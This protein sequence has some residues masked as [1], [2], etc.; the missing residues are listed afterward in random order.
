MKKLFSLLPLLFTF[1]IL[2]AQN[3]EREADAY[4]DEGNFTA[5]Q[6]LYLKTLKTDSTNVDAKHRLGICYLG[7]NIERSV[8]IPLLEFVVKQDKFD[9]YAWYDLARAY[10]YNHQFD[11]AIANYKKYIAEGRDDLFIKLAKLGKEQCENAK[12][13][14]AK[15]IDVAFYN[16]GSDVNT[17][18]NEFQP[19]I[20]AD[21][22]TLVYT[23]DQ[24]FDSRYNVHINNVYIAEN[25]EGEWHRPLTVG[26]VNSGEDEFVSGL[27]ANDEFVFI[28]YQRY[29]A[30]DDIF[31]AEKKEKRISRPESIGEFINTSAVESGATLSYSGDTL[32]FASDRDG[33]L[34]GLDLWMSLK[35]PNGNWATPI[36][37]GEPI[38]TPYD[39]DFP[40]IMPDGKNMF[41]SSTGHTSMGGYDVF[42]TKLNGTTGKWSKPQNFG[43]PVN[44]TYD[45]FT[46]AMSSNHRYAYVS[47][48]R[49]EGKGGMDI[50][51]IVF[52]NVNAN[53]FLHKGEIV[54]GE[55]DNQ[56][57][58]SGD[59]DVEIKVHDVENNKLFGKYQ[60]NSDKNQ[61]L[62]AL[63]PG[64]FTLFVNAEGFKPYKEDVFVPDLLKNQ[65][66][67][68]KVTLQSL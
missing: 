67:N 45:N 18:F 6:E 55:G 19:Y 33:G 8:A 22:S 41:F 32:I 34:G 65:T 57:A 27:A 49:P 58:L 63:P 47:D 66:Y 20:P 16:V 14:I 62:L 56:T 38:N 40:H 37:M 50:Y 17:E 53:I 51:R 52:H 43:Y 28:K 31:I 48:V 60:Y 13:L 26:V 44:N 23:S 59:V 7:Q 9:T 12:M 42:K 68:I 24:K 46:I 30:F 29:E 61:F 54:T 39:E 2:S 25:D 3:F 21:E 4:F 1:Y 64:S 10:H 15:P 35:L 11:E 5:A 36:N